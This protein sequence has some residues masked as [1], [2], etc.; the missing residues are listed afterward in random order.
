MANDAEHLSCVYWLF[1]YLIWRNV[2]SDTLL[3]L[4]IFLLLSYKSTLWGFPGGAV[5]ENL[6]ANAGDTG[7]SPGLGG[8]HMPRSNWACASG[9]RAPQRERLRQWEARAPRWR[10]APARR[11]WRKPSHRNEDP[12]QPKINKLIKKKKSTLYILDTSLLSGIYIVCRY[13]LPFSG[14]PYHSVD[15]VL[16]CTKVLFW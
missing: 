16:W 3:T 5:V 7:S 8:S 11:N 14:L 15:S 6:P 9:A 12:T 2:C 13:F 1:V 4:L 10:V